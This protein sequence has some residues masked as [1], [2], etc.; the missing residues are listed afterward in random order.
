MNEE[1]LKKIRNG[2]RNTNC[3]FSIDVINDKINSKEFEVVHD[4]FFLGFIEKSE[5]NFSYLY[6]YIENRCNFQLKTLKAKTN[7]VLDIIFSERK[8]DNWKPIVEKIEQEGFKNYTFFNRM[9]LNNYSEKTIDYK[10][11]QVINPSQK[12]LVLIKQFLEKN[13]DIFAERIPTLI[14][15]EKLSKT[16]YLIKAEENEIAAL[17]ISD[18]KGITEELRYW[19]VNEKYREKGFGSILMK[20]FLNHNTDT[21]RFLL[22]VQE[23]NTNAIKKYKHFGF[24]KDKLNMY[25]FKK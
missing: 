19:L 8:N 5:Y 14:E 4:D 16:T 18:K 17:L 25:I 3:F 21:T 13:F 12:D 6:F 10:N 9:V 20:Y 24:Q 1:V 22:W 23:D 2:V 11:N 15:L 7:L